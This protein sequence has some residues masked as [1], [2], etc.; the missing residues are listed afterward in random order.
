MLCFA[1]LYSAPLHPFSSHCHFLFLFHL[2]IEYTSRKMTSKILF[3][4]I[5]QS[6]NRRCVGV[7]K[8]KNGFGRER[9]RRESTWK[10]HKTIFLLA[11]VISQNK[12]EIFFNFISFSFFRSFDWGC[13]CCCC[14][15]LPPKT[16]FISFIQTFLSIYSCSII[17][18]WYTISAW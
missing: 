3:F 8:K 4:S 15:C 6:I 7:Q 5:S 11:Y 12:W 10:K 13:C 14:Y 1:L 17:M 18:M 16:Y 2:I 9:E